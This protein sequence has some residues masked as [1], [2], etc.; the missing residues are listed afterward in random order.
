VSHKVQISSSQFKMLATCLSF[1]CCFVSL[2]FL[3][4]KNSLLKLSLPGPVLQTYMITNV[5][6]LLIYTFSTPTSSA[7]TPSHLLH[8][9]SDI[10]DKCLCYSLNK[11]ES[12][13]IN[14][15]QATLGSLFSSVVFTFQLKMLLLVLINNCN[16]FV[17]LI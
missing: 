4:C 15:S 3:K 17:Y 16:S 6:R 11:I 5:L 14:P 9:L 13:S 8:T 1:L 12:V 10:L 2:L 7:C